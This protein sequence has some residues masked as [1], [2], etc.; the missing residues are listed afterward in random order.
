MHVHLFPPYC[1]EWFRDAHLFV[2]DFVK[3]PSNVKS[4]S[5]LMNLICLEMS[6]TFVVTISFP[7]RMLLT[8]P[9]GQTH[10]NNNNSLII[11]I[12]SYPIRV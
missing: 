8:V 10:N 12:T 7:S 3:F 6:E 9:V 4:I 1:L 5:A 2:K 11:E